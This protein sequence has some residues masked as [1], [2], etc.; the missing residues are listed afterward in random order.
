MCF[1]IY[2]N[3]LAHTAYLEA[4]KTY[5]EKGGRS[6]G[7]FLVA[8]GKNFR[9]DADSPGSGINLC[10]YDRS[11]ESDILELRFLNGKFVHNL[12]K[13]REIP[14]QDLWFEKVW[15]DYLEDNYLQI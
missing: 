6:R 11:V 10:S 3:C 1:R 7:S 9:M 12:V 5:I 4:I 14:D 13:V 8:D 15:K 2:D